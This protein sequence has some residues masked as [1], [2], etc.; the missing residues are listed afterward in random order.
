MQSYTNESGRFRVWRMIYTYS[1]PLTCYTHT[2][3]NCVCVR[4]RSYPTLKIFIIVWSTVVLNALVSLWLH[5]CWEAETICQTSPHQTQ[6]E[7]VGSRCP[8]L[9]VRH[10]WLLVKNRMDKNEPQCSFKKSSST[11]AIVFWASVYISPLHHTPHPHILVH[12][13]YSL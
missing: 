1:N 2:H 3:T 12:H 4:N 10:L 13:H 5:T 11:C 8:M 7:H 6:Q 9:G